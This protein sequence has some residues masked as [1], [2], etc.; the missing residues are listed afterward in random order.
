MTSNQAPSD[1][2]LHD[3]VFQALNAQVSSLSHEKSTLLSEFIALQ[4]NFLQEQSTA[5]VLN[6]FLTHAC[7]P[8]II[9]LLSTTSRTLFLFPFYSFFLAVKANFFCNIYFISEIS[10]SY[11][12]VFILGPYI[13]P[14]SSD[15][16]FLL[17]Y[18][19]ILHGFHSSTSPG[20]HMNSQ[21]NANLYFGLRISKKSSFTR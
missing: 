17:F 11:P 8:Q 10:K 21:P 19:P 7:V 9:H 1:V 5:T 18:T 13:F 2:K 12:N 20:A 6:L 4:D 3:D 16:F 14:R 15:N